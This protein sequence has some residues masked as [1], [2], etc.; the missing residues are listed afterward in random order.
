MTIIFNDPTYFIGTKGET[1]KERT[2]ISKKIPPQMTNS[3]TTKAVTEI[4]KVLAPSAKGFSLANFSLNMIL[5]ATLQQLWTMINAQQV[6]VVMIAYDIKPPGVAC[7]FFNL[8]FQIESVDVIPW[9]DYYDEYLQ[10]EHTEPMS[11]NLDALGY[12]NMYFLY[13]LGSSILPIALLLVKLVLW[14][15][16]SRCREFRCCNYLTLKLEKYLFWNGTIT[17][18]T[19]SF[20][21]V[22][23]SAFI[24]TSAVSKPL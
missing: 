1:I 14:L 22:I 8:L 2:K 9:S 13:N 21:A 24:S 12:N 11:V 7:F 18:I 15:L 5:A 20:S 16:F 4:K 23:L 6:V 10:M 19:E 17:V 3:T